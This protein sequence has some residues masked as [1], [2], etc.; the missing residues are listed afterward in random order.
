MQTMKCG[1]CFFLLG[2]I[3]GDN[4]IHKSKEKIMIKSCKNNCLLISCLHSLFGPVL[5]TGN[6]CPCCCLFFLCHFS[7]MHDLVLS[8][9]WAQFSFPKCY[10]RSM[11]QNQCMNV[12]QSVCCPVHQTRSAALV[13]HF[14]STKFH[15]EK[16]CAES[17]RFSANH[18]QLYVR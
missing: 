14:V 12:C 18:L 1:Q 11:C 17:R 10:W 4:S 7:S 15:L 3:N 2:D 5:V 13:L 9:P 8:F 6:T 16:V